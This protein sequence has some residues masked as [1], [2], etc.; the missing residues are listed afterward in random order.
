MSTSTDHLTTLDSPGERRFYPRS[1]PSRPIYIPFGA[2]NLCILLNLS[3]NGFL[4]ST[5]GGLDRNSVYRVSIR[6]NGVAKPIEVPVRTVWTTESR[7]RAG[8]QMLDL[9]DHDREQIRKWQALENTREKPA[10]PIA[11]EVATGAEHKEQAPIEQNVPP[12]PVPVI[13]PPPKRPPAPRIAAAA[14]RATTTG[15]PIA[16]LQNTHL[17]ALRSP[18][19]V[20]AR[21]RRKKSEALALIAWILVGA[22]ACVGIALLMRPE[23]FGRILMHSQNGASSAAV[24]AP[25][26]APESLKALE[27]RSLPA[28]SKTAAGSLVPPVTTVTK[29][30]TTANSNADAAASERRASETSSSSEGSAAT[31]ARNHFALSTLSRPNLNGASTASIPRSNADA[32]SAAGASSLTRSGASNTDLAGDSATSNKAT[33]T[34][35]DAQLADNTPSAGTTAPITTPATAATTSPAA[36][37]PSEKSAISGSIGASTPR[38]N[39][40]AVSSSGSVPASGASASRSIWNSS[41]PVAAG[42]SSLLRSRPEPGSSPVVHMDVAEA[43]VM[44]ITPPRGIT[45]SFMTL[46]GERVLEVSGMTLHIRRAVRVPSDRWIWHS[47]KQLVL[48]ELSTRVDP[49]VTRGGPGYGSVTIQAIIDKDGNVSDLKPLRGPSSLLPSVTRAVREWHYE[50]SYLDG[51]PV[52]TRAEIEVDFHPGTNPRS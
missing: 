8:I 44:E 16:E 10:E 4:I 47:K 37:A 38:G 40:V 20:V 19:A 32:A 43:H 11:P 25:R 31:A 49:Q 2:N 41:G 35:D 1:T 39:D 23:L 52:E 24:E 28:T 21:R 18:S 22:V 51:K 7:E 30:T 48:G 17:D 6:L 15:A 3:E 45:S 14:A 5:P 33:P 42:R 26:N 13:P 50:E 27:A 9:S 46:P 29:P 34:A 12:P 36:P